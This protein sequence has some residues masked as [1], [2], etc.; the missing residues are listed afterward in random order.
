MKTS[1]NLKASGIKINVRLSGGWPDVDYAGP[2]S[3]IMELAK[4]WDVDDEYGPTTITKQEY[5]LIKDNSEWA[6]KK[7]TAE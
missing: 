4:E 3:V 7:L 6:L 2:K 5:D 1:V